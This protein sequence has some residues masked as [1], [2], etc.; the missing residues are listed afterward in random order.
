MSSQTTRTPSRSNSLHPWRPRRAA[1]RRVGCPFQ[2]VQARRCMRGAA[3]PDGAARGA[4]VGLGQPLRGVSLLHGEIVLETAAAAALHRDAQGH[5]GRS[6]RRAHGRRA[7][8]EV[9]DRRNERGKLQLACTRRSPPPA[10]PSAAPPRC[11]KWPGPRRCRC[12]RRRH[13]AAWL[14]RWPPARPTGVVAAAAVAAARHGQIA[15]ARLLLCLAASCAAWPKCSAR[16]ALP[17]TARAG[18]R[19]GRR[20]GAGGG[21]APARRSV[22][23]RPRKQHCG[24][25]SCLPLLQRWL[26]PAAPRP[27]PCVTTV[28]A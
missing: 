13:P 10:A 23:Q 8:L 6:L 2:R 19:A 21:A 3:L 5:R 11:R 18:Q 20:R 24:A 17:R 15:L 27:Q 9:A 7:G 25:P 28:A 22:L 12:R 26:R 1:C 4:P 14:V 16:G